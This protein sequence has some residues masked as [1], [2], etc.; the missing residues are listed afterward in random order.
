MTGSTFDRAARAAA[1][2]LSRRA[3]LLTLGTAGL[4]ALA[5]PSLAEAKKNK[6]NK[7]QKKALQKCRKQEGQCLESVL[8][9]CAGSSDSAECEA[10]VRQCCQ[11]TAICDVL[12]FF[13][14]LGAA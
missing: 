14:C 6:K 5:T 7:T 9:L 12:G 2:S 8:P 11:L 13:N 10:R 1:A 3:S 4:T